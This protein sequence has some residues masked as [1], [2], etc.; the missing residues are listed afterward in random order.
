MA[1]HRTDPFLWC[2]LAA[3][4]AVPIG[5]EGGLLGLAVGDPLLP[6]NLDCLFVGLLGTVP[7]LALQWFRP[8]YPFS[9]PLVSL[10]PAYLSPSQLQVLTL[11]Q[12]VGA[13][14]VALAGA[15]LG[16]VLLRLTYQWAPIAAEVVPV[17]GRLVGLS[18]AIAAFFFTNLWLQMGLLAAALLV[19]PGDMV[20]NATP[21]PI[22]AIN[23]G[24]LR[25]GVPL[26]SILPMVGTPEASTPMA[27]EEEGTAEQ[28]SDVASPVAEEMSSPSSEDSPLLETEDSSPEPAASDSLKAPMNG[29]AEASSPP[30]PASDLSTDESGSDETDDGEN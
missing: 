22:D 12:G 19:A 10:R 25:W 18:L 23:R 17:D 20:D 30:A 27:T 14:G 11:A 3:L 26:R 6:A 2:H 5:L 13:K 7:L 1:T 24:F 29:D 4:A 8:I 9:I 15:A 16:L 28:N 21:F